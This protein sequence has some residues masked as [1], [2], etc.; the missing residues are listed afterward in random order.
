MTSVHDRYLVL[1]KLKKCIDRTMCVLPWLIGKLEIIIVKQ[2][3]STIAQESKRQ[4]GVLNHIASFVCT[5][6]IDKIEPFPVQGAEHILRISHNLP[7]KMSMARRRDV[8]VK[9]I[10]D[11]LRDTA[12]PTRM[13]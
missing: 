9:G 3:E 10:H 12:N 1:V 6:N 13:F 2:K 5:I 7:T 8:P 11:F 4:N